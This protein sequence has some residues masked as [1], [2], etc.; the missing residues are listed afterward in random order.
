MGSQKSL[1]GALS[2]DDTS[3]P[4]C[5]GMIALVKKNNFYTMK[6]Y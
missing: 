2:K 3:H 5:R 1:K 6:E 4:K